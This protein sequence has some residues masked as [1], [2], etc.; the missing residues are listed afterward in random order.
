MSRRG[1]THAESHIAATAGLL[2]AL[3]ATPLPLSAEPLTGPGFDALFDAGERA[4]PLFTRPEIRRALAVLPPWAAEDLDIVPAGDA[5]EDRT[6]SISS[7]DEPVVA[8]T[9]P[10]WSFEERVTFGEPADP[11]FVNPYVRQSL[12]ALPP[13]AAADAPLLASAEPEPAEAPSEE[14]VASLPES[15]AQEAGDI[16]EE[17]APDLS[18]SP[19]PVRQEDSEPSQPVEAAQMPETA[20]MPR[21]EDATALPEPETTAGV[22]E[23]RRIGA[24]RASWYEHPGQTASGEVFDPEQLTAAHHTLPFGTRVRVVNDATGDSIV[25]RINDRIPST[26]RHV[27]IDLSRESARRIGITGIADVK[28][29]DAG[30]PAAKVAE[31]VPGD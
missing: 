10:T 31:Q 24:G 27:V 9:P 30:D 12:A 6:A 4:E 15:P 8:A 26:T 13:W 17:A 7:R 3:G 2:C 29:Y 19:P 25:V 1:S 22:D 11:T 21:S 5:P 28:L 23:T 20:Q 14:T 18:L 16:S